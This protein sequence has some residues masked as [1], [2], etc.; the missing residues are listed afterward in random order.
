VKIDRL[1][2][3]VFFSTPALSTEYYTKGK[4]ESATEGEK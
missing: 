3:V 1:D 4:S 2:A